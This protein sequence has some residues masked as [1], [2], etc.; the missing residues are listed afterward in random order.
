MNLSRRA[1]SAFILVLDFHADSVKHDFRASNAGDHT[2]MRSH[3]FASSVLCTRCLNNAFHQGEALKLSNL[4]PL[5]SFVSR[6][7]FSSFE[8]FR[9]H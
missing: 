4:F 2:L 8:T 5:F 3:L 9:S 1:S 6:A 7:C